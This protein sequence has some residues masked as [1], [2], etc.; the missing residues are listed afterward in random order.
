M[1]DRK[2]LERI[3]GGSEAFGDG[4]GAMVAKCDGGECVPVVSGDREKKFGEMKEGGQKQKR[5]FERWKRMDRVGEAVEGGVRGWA[6]M[7]REL[8]EVEKGKVVMG[9][10]FRDVQSVVKNDMQ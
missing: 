5:I 7:E 6:V 2:V 9:N 4:K 1:K 3:S 10:C 8:K